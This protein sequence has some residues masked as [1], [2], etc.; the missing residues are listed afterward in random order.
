V[1]DPTT[2]PEQASAGPLWWGAAAAIVA[3]CLLCALVAGSPAAHSVTYA[4]GVL[5]LSVG[6][7]ATVQRRRL[8]P[9]AGWR[10]FGVG[11]VVLAVGD[12]VYGLP[13][14]AEIGATGLSWADP[15]FLLG[16][17]V[18]ALG[19]LRLKGAHWGERDRESLVD[20]ASV[21]LA[22]GV[23]L[24]RPLIEPR[25][26]AGTPISGRLAD[27]SYPVLDVVVV[28]M[29]LW[30]LLGQRRWNATAV[31]M[32]AGSVCYLA[33][34]LSFTWRLEHGTMGE[35]SLDWLDA[36]WL[37]GYGCF[38]LA[39]L[40]PSAAHLGRRTGGGPTPISR[41]RLVL[42]GVVL[43]VPI[44]VLAVNKAD[45][46]HLFM[47]VVVEAGLVLLVMIRL[48]DLAARERRARQA[49][50]DRERYFR[51]LAQNAA[52]AMVVLDRA[53]TV[54]DATPAVRSL[55]GVASGELV[56]RRLIDAVDDLDRDAL[57]HV[58]STATAAPGVVLSGEVAVGGPTA[59]RWLDLRVTNLLADPAVAGLV[60]NVQ[61]VTARHQVQADLERRAYTDPLT[62][63]AN[64]SL[65][66]DRLDRLLTSPDRGTVAVAYLD[67]DGFKG[68]NDRFGHAEGDRLLQA[69]TA[70]LA[71]I[72]RSSDT[73]A[74]LGGDEFAVLIHGPDADVVAGRVAERIVD[75]LGR[76]LR[77]GDEVVPMAVSVGVACAPQGSDEGARELMH[78]ADEA[79]YRA[80]RAG[81]DRVVR[82]PCRIRLSADDLDH[83]T[84]AAG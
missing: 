67:L 26:N 73:V 76:P 64:R 40:H 52:D 20:A 24:W 38:L 25:L 56:G 58:L 17:V 43:L 30:V 22:A 77:V 10:T 23:L 69:T 27:G 16:S 31:L 71:A 82:L 8:A 33:G 14:G 54:T 55:L 46:A 83:P 18:V 11:L 57:T 74:R 72:V 50:V 6:F 60:V 5:V 13:E 49:V 34:D 12:T 70:R 62:G 84:A 4:G 78:A 45:P 51:S 42:S 1:Q 66:Q 37:V 7:L 2:A 81:G 3:L 61:D 39:A 9:L 75:E 44:V 21:G 41:T 59:T 35:A 47:G 36:T 19:A 79:M 29:M 80:K 63:L 53:G 48:S 68:V 32:L 65:F 28:A 15:F